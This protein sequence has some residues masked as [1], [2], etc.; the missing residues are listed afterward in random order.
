MSVAL[1]HI[2]KSYDGVINVVDDVSFGAD[3]GEF[4]ALLGESGSGKTTTLKL[5]NR[6]IEPSS[7]R[8]QV[9]GV[10]VTDIDAVT[11]RRKIGYAFQGV[12]LFP[13]MT[14]EENIGI[15]PRLLQW[16]AERV[17]S[18]I[19]ELLEQVGLDPSDYRERYPHELSGGQ[20]Q[21]IGFARALAAGP[22]TM[23]LDEPFGALDPLTRDQLRNEFRALQRK[24]GFTTIMV[25]HDM[26][27]A[28]I[29]A[30]RIVVM[31]AGK[32][33][34]NGTPRSLIESPNDDYVTG[35]L[36]TPKREARAIQALTAE[37]SEVG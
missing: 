37:Q 36:A 21:R 14:V 4:V 29:L 17:E 35:M 19:A 34:Q 26:A 15:T 5:I 10:S 8:I 24:L 22:T 18:R 32:I 28:L 23:L 13:H 20:K 6:L 12:G 31:R 9:D 3:D 33:V 1:E 27:E 11:L 7:G 16:S 30:D 2:V 25:T